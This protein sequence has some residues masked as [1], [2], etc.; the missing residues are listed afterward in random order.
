[1]GELP[2]LLGDVYDIRLV[3]LDF[4]LLTTGVSCA[5]TSIENAASGG[6]CWFFEDI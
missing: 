2:S 6:C 1:M 5:T 3:E 4:W